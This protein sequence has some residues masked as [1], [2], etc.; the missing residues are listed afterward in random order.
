MG[1]DIA[2]APQLT[3]RSYLDAV[4]TKSPSSAR[5]VEECSR[6]M[7]VGAGYLMQRHLRST[8]TLLP[9]SATVRRQAQHER[10]HVGVG[11]QHVVLLVLQG[12]ERG[13]QPVNVVPATEPSSGIIWEP[14]PSVNPLRHFPTLAMVHPAIDEP[15]QRCARNAERSVG[16]R[17]GGRPVVVIDVNL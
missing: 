9:C 7:V 16:S 13:R 1:C 10:E 4:H 12:P 15:A 14:H 2:L 6:A 5:T 11:V 3:G 17:A 8:G